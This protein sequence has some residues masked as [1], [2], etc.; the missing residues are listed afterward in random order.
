MPL[1]PL[2]IDEVVRVIVNLSNRAAVRKSFDLALLVGENSVISKSDRLK[3]YTSTD[4]MLQAGFNNSDRLF[5][6]AQL[7]FGQSK[8]P[9]HV[10][11]GTKDSAETALQ[12]VQACRAAN[13]D[14]YVCV[15]C[16]D[17]TADQ[18]VEIATYINSCT[19]DSIYAYTVA[20]ADDYGTGDQSTFKKIKDK[21]LRRAIGQYSTKH[22]DSICAVLGYALG[23]M[24]GTIGSAFTLAYKQEVGVE[25]ENSTS[26]FSEE[27]VKNILANY[28]NVYVNRG[29][30]YDGFE[31]GYMGDGSWFDEIIYLDKLKNDIQFNIM[32]LLYSVPKVEQEESGMTRLHAKIAEVMEQYVNIGFIADGTKWRGDDILNLKKGDT[33]PRGYLVQ[34]ELIETQAQADRDNRIAPPIYV[35]MNLSGA[36]Q[37]VLIR[38]DVNR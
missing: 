2:S 37:K 18:H 7:L 9:L 3:M 14:W 5:K 16:A 4:E 24:T 6:A 35:A 28:G 29:G 31:L 8:R 34:S 27:K 13:S 15:V 1:A 32:D 11:V 36:I 10:M 12:A 22:K 19:P 23:S 25:T 30:H 20:A 17:L 33:L 21:K 26:A 38:F